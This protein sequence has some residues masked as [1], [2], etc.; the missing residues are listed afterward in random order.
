LHLHLTD[1]QGWRIESAAFPALAEVASWRAQTWI[2]HDRG[3]DPEEADPKAFDGTPHGGFYTV[4]DL[5]EIT[6]HAAR[7]GITIIPEVDLPGHAS[8]LLAAIPELVTPGCPTPTV[9]ETFLP[10]GRVVTPL[11]EGRA[12]L[13]TLITEVAEAIDSPYVHIGGDEASLADWQSSP[14]VAAH[15]A[16]HGIADVAALRTDLT[17]FLVATVEGLGRRAIVWEEAFAAGGISPSTIVMAW[18]GEAR[19][20]A[21]LEAGHDV[22]MSPMQSCYLDYSEDGPEG[23]LA[24]GSEMTIDRVAAYAPAPHPGP[25]QLL[26]VQAALWGEFTPDSSTRSY[27]TF[28]RLCVHATNAWSGTPTP[29]PA[30]RPALEKHLRRLDAAGIEYRPLDGPHPWQLGGTGRRRMDSPLTLDTIAAMMAAA[31]AGPEMPDI[32]ELMAHMGDLGGT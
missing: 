2:G 11:P 13:A 25:G 5:R 15:M 30:S 18:M 26:G 8:A 31:T 14:E 1:D 22:I 32:E 4:A 7:H 29:W 23:R 6:A 28:P 9:A 16:E 24:L 20:I 27:R 21:A 3:A 12:I 10:S 17:A 19:G